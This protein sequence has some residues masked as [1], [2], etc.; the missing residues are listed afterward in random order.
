MKKFPRRPYYVHGW[1]ALWQCDL[2]EMTASDSFKYIFIMI[3]IYTL[4]FW[5]V[6]LVDKKSSTVKGEFSKI[7]KEYGPPKK[8][9]TDKGEEGSV[10]FLLGR[11]VG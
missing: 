6:A 3:D 8:L 9:E 4:F 1:G 2:A 5:A 11:R 7:F 10:G